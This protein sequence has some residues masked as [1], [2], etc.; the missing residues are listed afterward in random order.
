MKTNTKVLGVSLLFVMFLIGITSPGVQADSFNLTTGNTDFGVPS[1][2]A[3][4]DLTVA[5]GTATFVFTALQGGLLNNFAFN[6]STDLTLDPGQFT[7]MPAGWSALTPSSNLDSYGVFTWEVAAPTSSASYRVS[8]FTFVITG[9]A[10]EVTAADFEILTGEVPGTIVGGNGPAMF[11][12]HYYPPN[13]LETGFID[14]A[15]PVPEPGILILLGI[16][17][18]AV[19]IVSRYVRKI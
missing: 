14:G 10:A 11:A 19:G 4:L 9:L 7:T 15:V 1:P 18:S 12:A 8:S 2:Y 13:G 17:M 3:H 5:S 16:A 6:T